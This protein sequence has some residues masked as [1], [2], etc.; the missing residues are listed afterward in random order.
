[1]MTDVIAAIVLAAGNSSRMEG[2]DKLW[3]DLGGK[4]VVARSLES[5]I[6]LAVLNLSLIHI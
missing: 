5:L 6:E 4:P 3:A 1:M 2:D